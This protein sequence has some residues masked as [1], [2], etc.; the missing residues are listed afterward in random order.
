M[1]ALV[2][3]DSTSKLPEPTSVASAL[4]TSTLEASA[5]ARILVKIPVRFEFS[6]LV[7]AFLPKC[8][9]HVYHMCS[10]NRCLYVCLGR[11]DRFLVPQE[12]NQLFVDACEC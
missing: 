1:I 8:V 3:V 2:T 12:C 11:C 4:R 6:F 5:S 9:K 7:F 10:K